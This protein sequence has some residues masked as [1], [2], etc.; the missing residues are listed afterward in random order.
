[1]KAMIAMIACLS[2][3][4]FCPPGSAGETPESLAPSFL[5]AFFAGDTTSPAIEFLDTQIISGDETIS[6]ASLIEKIAR[7]GTLDKETRRALGA[8]AWTSTRIPGG[9][10]GAIHLESIF[11]SLAGFKGNDIVIECRGKVDAKDKPL[12]SPLGVSDQCSVIVVMRPENG[13]FKIVG[14]AA[15]F[16]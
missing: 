8:V 12:L 6:R 13:R 15:R 9:I 4:L 3:G 14:F 2:L 1:M 11:H 10:Q 16:D 5:R 7:I